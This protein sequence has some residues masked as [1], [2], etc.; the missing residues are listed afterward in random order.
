VNASKQFFYSFNRQ[1]VKSNRVFLVPYETEYYRAR[2]DK[3]D[4][5]AQKVTVFYIDYG[6]HEVV[7]IKSMIIIDD[8]IVQ[9][10]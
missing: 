4:A 9:Q 6:N 3:V 7:D 5:V 2:A 10:V 8:R 1:D